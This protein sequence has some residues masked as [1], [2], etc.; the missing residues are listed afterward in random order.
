LRYNRKEKGGKHMDDSKKKAME[1]TFADL[2]KLCCGR[3]EDGDSRVAVAIS[4]DL[5]T[6][7][8]KVKPQAQI[9]FGNAETKVFSVG[10]CTV[11]QSD[12]EKSNIS[13]YKKSLALT[14][15]WIRRAEAGK[16]SKNL[17]SL[18]MIPLLL[19]SQIYIVF[20][21]PAYVIGSKLNDGRYR[22]AISFATEMSQVFEDETISYASVVKSVD[23]EIAEQK[24]EVEREAAKAIAEYQD[25]VRKAKEKDDIYA[26]SIKDEYMD[27]DSLSSEAMS[28]EEADELRRKSTGD[29]RFIFTKD[30]GKFK[31]ADDEDDEDDEDEYTEN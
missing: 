31:S 19:D 13:A 4:A 24:K 3:D 8:G 16:A 1:L 27:T 15:A 29:D 2:L 21:S 14:Q 26:Q 10:G 25:A 18:M 17:Y 23:D 20:N 22:L 28:S 12:F 11:I 5:L 7:D 30:E 6:D 9:N